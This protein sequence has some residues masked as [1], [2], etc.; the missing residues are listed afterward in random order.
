MTPPEDTF[1][2]VLDLPRVGGAPAAEPVAPPDDDFSDVLD[3][4]RVE[5]PLAA[6]YKDIPVDNPDEAA[7]IVNLSRQTGEPED[8]VQANLAEVQAVVSGPT[9]GDLNRFEQEAPKTA[10][11][12]ANPKNMAMAHDD[13]E[14]LSAGERILTGLS[15]FLGVMAGPGRAGLAEKATAEFGQG[16]ASGAENVR[17]AELGW[18]QAL[19]AIATGVHD[20]SLDAELTDL[21]AKAAVEAAKAP[22]IS[23]AYYMG[24]QVPN[25]VLMAKKGLQRGIQAGSL[26]GAGAVVAGGIPMIPAT[27]SG[28][29][30][31]GRMGVGEAAMILEGGSAYREFAALRDQNGNPVNPRLAGQMAVAVGAANAGME[32]LSLA[33]L[34]RIPGAK[35]LL[36]VFSKR[37]LKTTPKEALKEAVKYWLM[38]TGTE[39]A[40]EIGQEASAAGGADAVKA[41]SGQP[42]EGTPR[43]LTWE[44]VGSIISPTVQATLLMGAPGAFVTAM[45]QQAGVDGG[46]QTQEAYKALGEAADRSKLMKRS[47][48]SYQEH[49]E[50]VTVD[51][52]AQTIYIPADAFVEFCQNNELDPAG[53]AEQLGVGMLYQEARDAGGDLEIPTAAWVVQS[54]AIGQDAGVDIYNGLTDD[55]KFVQHDLTKRQKQEM[56]RLLSTDLAT[57]ADEA[58]KADTTG[59]AEKSRKAIEEERY[60]ELVKAGRPEK[61]ARDDAVIY[62]RAVTILATTGYREGPVQSSQVDAKLIRKI[63]GVDE[64]KA[65]PSFEEVL[66][67]DIAASRRQAYPEAKAAV[68]DDP[69]Y[70]ASAEVRRVLGPQYRNIAIKAY[71]EDFYHKDINKARKFAYAFH[72]A[73][74]MFNLGEGED[75]IKMIAESPSREEAIAKMLDVMAPERMYQ[76]APAVNTPEFKAW[77]GE[78]KVVDAEGK[79][80]VVY[81]GTS[82]KGLVGNFFNKELLGSVTKSRSAKAGFYFVSDKD[83]AAGYSRL[84]NEKPV[85]DLIAQSEAAERAKKWDLAHDLIAKAEKLEAESNPKERVEQVYLSIK[86]PLVFDSKEQRFLD[87]QDDIHDVIKKARENGNDGIVLK[88]LIDN[89]DWG[90]DRAADHYIAFSPTQIKSVFNRGTFDPNNPNIMFQLAQPNAALPLMDIYEKITEKILDL[91]SRTT[92]VRLEKPMHDQI[93]KMLKNFGK[94]YKMAKESAEFADWLRVNSDK[95]EAGEF[96]PEVLY[97]KMQDTFGQAAAGAFDPRTRNVLLSF[98]NANASTFL[99]EMAHAW[100][101]MV[102]EMVKDGRASDRLIADHTVLMQ[103]VGAKFDDVLTTEQHEKFAAAFEIYLREGKAPSVELKG[104]FRRLRNWLIRIYRSVQDIGGGGLRAEDISPEVRKVMDRMLASE[105]EIAYAEK[106]MDF[107]RDIDLSGVAPEVIAKLDNL[108]QQAHDEAVDEL[109]KL[110]MAEIAPENQ[111]ARTRKYNELIKN[112]TASL[113]EQQDYVVIDRMGKLFEGQS[114]RDVSQKYLDGTLTEDE[115]AAFDVA[116]DASGF[117]SG[118]EMA[119]RLLATKPLEEAAAAFADQIMKDAYPDYRNTGQI[120]EKALELVHSERQLEVLAL[121]REILLTK[122]EKRTAGV[123]AQR[124]GRARAWQEAAAAQTMA[125]EILSVKPV[126]EMRSPLPYFTA[127]RNA[128]MKVADALAKKDAARAAEWKRKQMVNHALGVAVMKVQKQVEKTARQIGD[129]FKKRQELLKDQETADQIAYL[130]ERFGFGR[131]P[132]FDPAQR[133]ESLAEYIQR[134]E[135]FFKSDAEDAT[136][137]QVPGWILNSDTAIPWTKLRLDELQDVKDTIYNITHVANMQDRFYMLDDK[138]TISQ[139]VAELV[140]EADKNVGAPLKSKVVEGKLDRSKRKINAG[141]YSLYQMLTIFQRLDGDKKDGL[142]ARLLLHPTNERR[143]AESGRMDEA[144]KKLRAII[145][146]Y[147]PG[148][149]ADLLGKKIIVPEFGL[150][151]DNALTKETLIAMLLNM[152]NEGNLD[153]LV[154]KPPVGFNPAF[155]WSRQ[156]SEKVVNTI[157]EVLE[158]HLDRRDF[159]VAQ[160]FWDAIEEYYPE[161]AANHK[162]MSGFAPAKIQAMPSEFTLKDGS[163]VQLRG[164]YYP[165]KKDPRGG[166]R[167]FAQ[168]EAETELSRQESVSRVASTRQSHTKKRT[169]G[170]YSV[171]LTLDVSAGHLNDVIH[172]VYCREL[173]VD[174]R[175]VVNSEEFYDGVVRNLGAEAYAA[176]KEWV[177]SIAT[178]GTADKLPSSGQAMNAINE[179]LR[180]TRTHA[181]ASIIM[182]APRVI[183][184]NLANVFLFGRAVQ[185]WTYADSAKAAIQYGLTNYHPKLVARIASLGVLKQAL[186]MREEIWSKSQFMKDRARNPEPTLKE[187]K[188]VLIK[189]DGPVKRYASTLLAWSDDLWNVPQWMGAYNKR[190]KE[191]G[192]E[193]EAIRFA[194]DLIK[195]AAMPERKED[196]APILRDPNEAVKLF[197]TFNSFFNAQFNRFLREE[198][199]RLKKYGHVVKNFGDIVHD[200]PALLGYATASYLFVLSSAALVG[201]LPDTDDPEE[202]AKAMAYQIARNYLSWIPL[203]RDVGGVLAGRMFGEG[204]FGGYRPSISA[205]VVNRMTENIWKIYKGFV[206][207]A[208]AEEILEPVSQIAAFAVPYPNA[209]NNLF[210]NIVNAMQGMEFEPGDLTGRRPRAER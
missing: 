90:A 25:T 32:Y 52:N 28:L 50:A 155:E 124:A 179:V 95:F 161:V 132:D 44:R 72:D 30:V 172:D 131:R 116:A 24:Q 60:A 127:E 184:Q 102:D 185:G 111:A 26:F 207:Q 204:Y 59:E 1:S 7:R 20:T 170:T 16:V 134:M 167:E 12:G 76:T 64:L 151:K 171:R 120:K 93:G 54:K 71:Q 9:A 82:E 107:A 69:L 133:K 45:H 196:L 66:D 100:L 176:I 68:D 137:Y 8:F 94:T 175:R 55:V 13:L 29:T 181:T 37:A 105:D 87:I 143:D 192:N 10:A 208:P 154:S 61:E 168:A 58:I 83:A 202:W 169:G 91:R 108:R 42:F 63:K 205:S 46:D 101:S 142:W 191:T 166:P 162:R 33:M 174:L 145:A 149:L 121:E 115:K 78:S 11:W 152:G 206:E 4:P 40:T 17:M 80:L 81:H 189:L 27:I 156:N 18:K 84:A 163:T 198:W 74:K 165:L 113:K 39:V 197:V 15:D 199:P 23:P 118:E 201:D 146:R 86:N 56:K 183:S 135:I 130:L 6:A 5:S 141:K 103:F 110:Q 126:G 35:N 99:H 119:E 140:A 92:D 158:R 89:A 160:A 129:V 173:V 144:G 150:D 157:R 38:Q 57:A 122:L 139:V 41:L 136:P 2:D 36:G 106:R 65:A 193:K 148:E 88:N 164:G 159:E 114:H 128:A 70:R 109:I 49:L 182:F 31:G 178:G 200:V 34:L 125:W 3:L 77:F 180:Y 123:V 22:K 112:H 85:A 48:E 203:V 51:G 104:V 194:D 117:Y 98:K 43:S 73:A 186:K 14:G 62:S 188:K 19:G 153:R 177:A 209:I 47:P 75:L 190:L 67:Q 97:Q 79:P 53:V 187:W 195:S 96:S 138:R 21:E 147:K 210:W